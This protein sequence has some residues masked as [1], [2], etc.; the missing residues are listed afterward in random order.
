MI[1]FLDL[2]KINARFEPKLKE[3]FQQFL[4]SGHYILG[5]E[6]ETFE[7]NFAAYCGTKH[8]IGTAN[9]LDA[10]ILIFRAYIELGK[11]QLNDEVIVPANTY[12]A[13]ILSIIHAGLKPV[14]V[15]PDEQTFNIS[16]T[17]IEKHITEKT[18]A[19]LVVHL[20]GQLADMAAIN[21]I[22]KVKNL[23][24]IED[25][26]QAHG[27]VA[28]SKFQIPNSNSVTL[29]AVE[30][31]STKF[32]KAGNLS[33]AAA[34]SF[35]PTKNLGCLGDGGAVTTNNDELAN[36]IKVMRNYGSSKK[37]VNEV[38]GLNSRLDELQAAFLNVKLK[39]LDADNE[40]RQAIAIRYRSEINNQ[41]INLPFWN[42][43]SN[44]VFH[45]F[46][47]RVENRDAFKAYL[48]M[49]GI[50]WLIHYP[51]PPHRQKALSMFNHLSFPITESIHQSVLSIPISPVMTEADVTAVITILNRY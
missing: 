1:K 14:L 46:L 32:L 44:H 49:N 10:L 13:S 15:E 7:S 31:P 40:R 9:G 23:L 37:Y 2:H 51:I 50:G 8:C 6:V 28:N 45:V 11:L 43:S 33:N 12:I 41:K 29:S 48:D 30:V 26:A 34:F 21:K 39:S 3:T 18:K 24:V 16:P 27:A 38:I 36:C 5:N 47:V 19:I 20:Y 35:Y 42:G 25:A 17:E 4:D 22:A